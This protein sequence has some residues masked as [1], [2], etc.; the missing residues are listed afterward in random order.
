MRS[1]RGLHR[2]SGFPPPASVEGLFAKLIL[3]VWMM[4][5]AAAL[6]PQSIA[7]TVNLNPGDDVPA[8]VT[9]SPAGTTFQFA[10]GLYRLTAP[11]VPLTSDTFLGASGQTTILSGA[12][13]LTSF[14]EQNGY[15]TAELTRDHINPTCGTGTACQ[16]Q[17]NFPGCDLPEDLFIDGKILQRVTAVSDVTS[18]KWFW[19]LNAGTVYLADDPN[20]HQVEISTTAQAFTGAASN[21]KIDGLAIEKFASQGVF[22]GILNGPDGHGW[23]V[24]N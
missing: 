23:T 7:G 21:V 8:I 5:L 12:K 13:L 9:N 16:C 10:A 3:L 11:V 6:A 15:W 17:P 1:S 2:A 18:G 14:T 19:D 4:I 20:G 22:A 24:E